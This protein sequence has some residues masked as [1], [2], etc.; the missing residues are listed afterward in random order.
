VYVP[1]SKGGPRADP[2]AAG[3]PA[4]W[5][6]DGEIVRTAYTPRADDDDWGQ[7]R[8]MVRAVL[9]DAART[10]LVGN[11]VAHLLDGVSP[12][13]LTRAFAYLRNIDEDLG[14][15]VEQGVRNKQAQFEATAAQRP[16][17][18]HPG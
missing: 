2:A 12:P 9:D 15:R 11:I 4:N 5:Y 3:P 14:D 1:N 7:A 8:T 13:V 18:G 16:K 17:V 10:R 6:A